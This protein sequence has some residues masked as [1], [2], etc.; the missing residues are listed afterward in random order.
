MV[1]C[2]VDFTADIIAQIQAAVESEPTISRRTLSRR[3]CTWLGWED[4]R[5]NPK[6]M[7][8]RVAL[9]RLH[10][11][12]V[13]ALPEVTVKIPGGQRQRGEEVPEAE[14]TVMECCLEELGCIDLVAVGRAHPTILGKVCAGMN[15]V[16]FKRGAY[17]GG[18]IVRCERRVWKSVLLKSA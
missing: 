12:G 18:G 7:S 1:V 16:A 4:A 5:G 11:R 14:P 17:R 9:L 6:S 2:G 8:C 15:F 3:V 13:L 10:R